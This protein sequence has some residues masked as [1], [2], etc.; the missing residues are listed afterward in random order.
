MDFPFLLSYIRKMK[1][2]F[3]GINHFLSFSIAAAKF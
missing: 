2:R 1:R 3:L